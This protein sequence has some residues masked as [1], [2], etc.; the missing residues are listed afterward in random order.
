[1][2]SSVVPLLLLSFVAPLAH[3]QVKIDRA[4]PVIER[5][6][7]DPKNKPPEMPKLHP[8]EAAV[9]QS[10]FGAESH[11]GGQV[12]ERTQTPQGYQSSIR[13]DSVHMILKLRITIWLPT[14]APPK[15]VKHE[16]AHR[17]LSERY[18]RDAEKIARRHAEALIGQTVTGTGDDYASA[19]DQALKRTAQEVGQR[20]LGD[21]D[22][23]CFKAQE[24]FDK[25]TAHGTNAVNE[26]KA[27]ERAI[28]E[29]AD[30]K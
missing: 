23:P 24:I 19:G 8:N 13:I 6:T 28:R 11:I 10:F 27:I 5:R 9:T 7:F 12:V 29:A 30:R 1:M 2:R 14:D 21:T 15:L 17:E 3:A 22:V 18:Y 4:E 20:Y 26:A 25:I 16:E